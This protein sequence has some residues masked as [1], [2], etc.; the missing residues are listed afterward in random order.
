MNGVDLLPLILFHDSGTFILKAHKQLAA[1]ALATANRGDFEI[2]NP[3]DIVHVVHHSCWTRRSNFDP[4]NKIFWTGDI[5]WR[6]D[7]VSEKPEW[8][9]H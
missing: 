3:G 9:V 4:G 2:L 8:A 6:T 5:Q 1:K 7:A